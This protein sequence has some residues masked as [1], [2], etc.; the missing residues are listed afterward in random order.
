MT[1]ALLSVLALFALNNFAWSDT[2]VDPALV[3]MKVN[4]LKVISDTKAEIEL[5][6]ELKNLG[7]KTYKSGE[8][9]QWVR[10][11]HRMSNPFITPQPKGTLKFQQEFTSLKV[12]ESRTFRYTTM[13]EVRPPGVGMIAWDRYVFQIDYHRDIRSDR[14]RDNDDANLKN[15]SKTLDAIDI[16]KK[17]ADALKRSSAAS[18]L[19][20]TYPNGG[21]RIIA[22]EFIEVRWTTK[23]PTPTI[24]LSLFR[25]GKPV[26]S[27]E[28]L[29][30]TGTKSGWHASWRVP[31]TLTPGGSYR[32][33]LDDKKA[34]THD[35]SDANFTIAAAKKPDLYIAGL[36]DLTDITDDR[37]LE[38][39]MWVMVGNQG[40]TSAND[41]AL[42]VYFWA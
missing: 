37:P 41:V 3:S 8:G 22:G 17:V 38:G 24:H 12:G 31:S 32:I 15:N 40:T 30:A 20:I 35:V 42:T 25:E 11:Y 13:W 7:G 2:A 26:G 34:G 18:K 14:N 9:Q 19:T 1:R 39:R 23:S 10:L 27:A 16:E 28:T 5:V 29:Y 21:E 33:R 4:V 6:V 36:G